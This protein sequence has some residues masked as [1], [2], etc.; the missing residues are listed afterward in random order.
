VRVPRLDAATCYTW[1]SDDE[2]AEEHAR[3]FTAHHTRLDGLLQ[4]SHAHRHQ[5]HRDC[6]YVQTDLEADR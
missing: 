2:P 3:E 1:L 5:Y 6:R 4:R